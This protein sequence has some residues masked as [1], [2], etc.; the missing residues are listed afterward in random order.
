MAISQKKDQESTTRSVHEARCLTIPDLIA[1]ELEGF[2]HWSPE[3]VEFNAD[4]SSRVD[5]L[6]GES[7]GKQACG[8]WAATRRYS[9][10]LGSI[11]LIQTILLRK[12]LTGVPV[13]W[14]FS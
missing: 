1:G 5:E 2:N 7:K 9:L 10:G 12:C 8:K 4:C 13:P 11:F 6:A 3:E 14:G